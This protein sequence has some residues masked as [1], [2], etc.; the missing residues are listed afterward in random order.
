MNIAALNHPFL[1]CLI[2]ILFGVAFANPKG[3]GG[4]GRGRGRGSGSTKPAR[5]SNL[6]NPPRIKRPKKRPPIVIH[7]GSGGTKS[8]IC[9]DPDTLL[10]QQSAGHL[11]QGQPNG[12]DNRHRSGKLGTD[13]RRYLP[14]PNTV[15]GVVVIGTGIY[16]AY[17]TWKRK[18]GKGTTGVSVME[19]SGRGEYKRTTDHWNPTV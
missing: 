3:G 13:L 1:L 8:T 10:L 11:S 7:T 15:A 5:P 2:S 4:G 12:K 6:Y 17:L 14:V 19:G 18:H 16:I 9:R